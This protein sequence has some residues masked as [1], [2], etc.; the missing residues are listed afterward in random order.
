MSRDLDTLLAEREI[1]RVILRYARGID[2]K[3]FDL[4]RGCFHPD[5]RVEYGD[6]FG[7]SVDEAIAWLADSLPRLEG[8]LH[9]FGPPWIELDLDRGTAACE[10]RAVNSARYAPDANGV[11]IQNVSGTRYVDR[12]ERRDG[13]WRLAFRRNEREWIQNSP[14][15]PEPAPPA[16]PGRS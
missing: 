1:T 14:D 3:D 7:G 2:A 5:A 4:V 10:T 9:T 15:L 8:T 6:W 13:E 16:P 11:S 12:F